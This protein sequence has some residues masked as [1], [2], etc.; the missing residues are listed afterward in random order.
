MLAG[1]HQKYGGPAES[2]ATEGLLR[3]HQRGLVGLLLATLQQLGQRRG[4]VPVLLRCSRSLLRQTQDDIPIVSL[5]GG[6]QASGVMKPN[7]DPR[8][9][10]QQLVLRGQRRVLE[11]SMDLLPADFDDAPEAV[12]SDI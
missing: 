11:A 3:G 5:G 1:H 7:M 12:A 6:Y 4:L 8:S 2:S 10:T 9:R